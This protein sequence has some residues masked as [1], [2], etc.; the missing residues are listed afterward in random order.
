MTALAAARL[1]RCGAGEEA[2]PPDAK[3]V[4]AK[5]EN[6]GEWL[7]GIWLSGITTFVERERYI[8]GSVWTRL[9]KFTVRH[10]WAEGQQRGN[11]D[12]RRVLEL[13]QERWIAVFGRMH[14]PRIDPEGAWR[15]KEAHERLS[16]M[17][18]V[19]DLPPGEASWLESVIENTTGIV[20]DTMTRI[21]LERPDLK[22]TEGLAS[23]V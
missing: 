8:Y 21:A 4:S 9:T 13:L 1:L 10:A 3:P 20:K 16:D 19:I 11:I 6:P 14:T 22:S 17:Q 5:I 2:K 23:A 18:I 7:V 12:G 15:N